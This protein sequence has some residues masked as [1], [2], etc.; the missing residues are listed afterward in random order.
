M[1]AQRDLERM[2][3]ERGIFRKRSKEMENQTMEAINKLTKLLTESITRMLDTLVGNVNEE[4]QRCVQSAIDRIAHLHY[5]NSGV[6]RDELE[7]L[8]NTLDGMG[9][10]QTLRPKYEERPILAIP[11]TVMEQARSVHQ[12]LKALLRSKE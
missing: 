12:S 2:Y 8:A 9:D 11:D 5:V 3:S 1:A 7:K 6:F 10:I 4:A